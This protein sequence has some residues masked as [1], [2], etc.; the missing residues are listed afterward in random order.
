MIETTPSTDFLAAL[1]TAVATGLGALP[2][3]FVRRMSARWTACWPM[4]T[5]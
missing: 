5:C 2:F 3:L 4:S 1:A